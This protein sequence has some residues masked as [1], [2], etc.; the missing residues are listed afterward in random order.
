M[1]KARLSYHKREIFGIP[2]LVG[3]GAALGDESPCDT[4]GVGSAPGLEFSVCV[5]EAS[6][7]EAVDG[8]AVLATEAALELDTIDST[9]GLKSPISIPRGRTYVV[10]T[11]ICEYWSHGIW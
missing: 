11:V 10:G 4:V 6:V 1:E 7:V 8:A 5:A 2:A 9:S 3:E